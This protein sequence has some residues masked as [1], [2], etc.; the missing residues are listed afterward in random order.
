MSTA[1]KR[2]NVDL[3]FLFGSTEKALILRDGGQSTHYVPNF[4]GGYTDWNRRLL[5]M[6]VISKSIENWTG[7]FESSAVTFP[8]ADTDGAVT[9]TLYGTYIGGYTGQMGSFKPFGTAIVLYSKVSENPTTWRPIF[10]GNVTKVER[11]SGI[12]SI[13]AEDNFRNL[14]NS[15]FV[16]DYIGIATHITTSNGVTTLYGTVKDVIGSLVMVDDKGDIQLI[17][18]TNEEDD[19]YSAAILK[20]ITGFVTGMV[21]FGG[22]PIGGLIGAGAGFIGEIPVHKAPKE[23]FYYKVS[24]FN[25]IPN[26]AVFGGQLLKFYQGTVSGR[27]SGTGGALYS[28]PAQRVRGGTFLN[29]F[30]GTIELDDL[31]HT[32]KKGDYIYAEV[33]L[34]FFGSPDD[35]LLSLLTGSNVTV[36]YSYPKDFADN[37]QEQVSALKHAELYARVT[38]FELGGVTK[39]LS[40]L[41]QECWLTLY[42]N[43][44]NKFSVRSIRRRQFNSADVLATITENYNVTGDGITLIDDTQTSYTN[45][46]I[47]YDDT[48]VGNLYQQEINRTLPAATWYGGQQRTYELNSEWIHDFTTANFFADRISRWN[49]NTVPRIRGECSLY[50]VPLSLAE[51][52]NVSA[53][54]CGSN[55]PYEIISYSKR[56]DQSKTEFL[57]EYAS[58]Y[59][60]ERGHFLVGS[61]F[62]TFGSLQYSGFATFLATTYSQ[63]VNSGSTLDVV[64]PS[65]N[66]I[67]FYWPTSQGLGYALPNGTYFRLATLGSEE[68][69]K[70][71]EW[72]EMSATI[73]SGTTYMVRGYHVERGAENTIPEIYGI[74]K[75]PYISGTPVATVFNIGTQYGS[76]FRWF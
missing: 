69:I 72:S 76:N 1:A 60:G 49:S 46:L 73:I 55:Q 41:A 45:L 71:I 47:K 53:W 20:G 5:E 6:P 62:D 36:R 24:D 61:N 50:A 43:E 2:F 27:A 35:V 7:N 59:Y 67:K 39:A 8:L 17:K 70:L 51:F 34:I 29:G 42:L 57:A 65:D 56:F 64:Y 63:F 30:Q 32:V 31:F 14:M 16:A 19:D 40:Q 74:G 75:F 15:Q 26:G 21:A 11:K 25:A 9:A 37:W 48:Y 44:R 13:T 28:V 38:N 54:G 22:N 23:T 68:I 12:T 58:F 33:P 10:A 52:A 3:L 4:V 66:V 18:R